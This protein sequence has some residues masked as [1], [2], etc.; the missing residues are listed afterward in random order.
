M[1]ELELV[2]EVVK[3]FVRLKDERRPFPIMRAEFEISRNFSAFKSQEI[4]VAFTEA[5]NKKLLLGKSRTA[6]A[7]PGSS[8]TFT[9]EAVTMKGRLFVQ[10][11]EEPER[12]GIGFV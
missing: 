4:L 8:T 5:L 3:H 12:G 1:R 2:Y 9:I 6:T 10:K 11:M 7:F